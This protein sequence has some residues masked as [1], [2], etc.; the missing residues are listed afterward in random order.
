MKISQRFSVFVVAMLFVACF[1]ASSFA[2]QSDPEARAAIAAGGPGYTRG[3]PR[4]ID[5]SQ[6]IQLAVTS[7]MVFDAVTGG[8]L[9]STGVGGAGASGSAGTAREGNE[10]DEDFDHIIPN[11][12]TIPGLD[13][14]ATFDGAF[15]AQAGPNSTGLRIFRFTMIGND[16]FRGETTL[17]PAKI[18]EV[19]LQLLNADGSTF[20]TVPFAP[21]EDLT[22]DSPNFEEHNYR[23]GN[24]LQYGDAIHRAQFFHTMDEDWHTILR[25]HVVS[26]ITVVVPRFVNVR[27]ANGNIIQA[28]S[29]FT[30]TAA[31]GSTF[32]LMLNLLFNFFFDNTVVNDIVGGSFTTDALNTQMWPNTF[33]F[34]LN[35][36]NP[37][38][39]GGCCV[40]GFHTF[41]FEPGLIPQPRWLTQFASWIS[42][43]IF[44]GGFQDVTALS[45]ETAETFGDPF[46][47]NATPSWQFPGVPANAK[48]CQNNLEEGDPIEV[49][50]TATIPIT[51]RERNE[52]FTYHPQI[53]PLLQW[54]EM[55]ATSNA[56]DGAFSFPD[57][58]VLPHSALPCP[59]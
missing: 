36:N 52:V 14:V 35:V 13:T 1:A 11:K 29:Y 17:I 25:P 46:I 39:P 16:P 41:F 40:L 37:N 24:H 54:F 27:L 57:E 19:S 44:G 8:L 53:I 6:P 26:R 47:D 55:G 12:P 34:S 38:T 31:D 2:Q 23:S 32:V 45:H 22:L 20:K 15:F 51:L 4:T 50:P 43:G 58:T 10:G 28:R 9:G 48:I 49:L 21:F 7:D 18:D 59:Q 33:L 30:G 3:A 5:R 42:P 56:V